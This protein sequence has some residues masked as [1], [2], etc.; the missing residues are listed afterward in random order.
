MK[1]KILLLII[2]LIFSFGCDEP[3]ENE[4]VVVEDEDWTIFEEEEIIK[5]EYEED[6][7]AG[8]PKNEVSFDYMVGD[9]D[10][11]ISA[12]N[13]SE[14][15]IKSI[16]WMSNTKVTITAYLSMNCAE[17]IKKMD[18][19]LDD[20]QLY[21]TYTIDHCEECTT[22]ICAKKITFVL[23][24]VEKKKYDYNLVGL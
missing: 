18:Y 13:L 3:A 22:C 11:A 17:S 6:K 23:D 2:I 4:P 24:G 21:I 15:G 16:K 10:D 12:Y 5:E 14:M 1:I 8:K 19:E 9:C 7:P 20:D